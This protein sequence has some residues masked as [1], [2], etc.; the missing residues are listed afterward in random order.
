[1]RFSILLATAAT[2]L[3]TTAAISTVPHVLHEKRDAAPK[4]WVKR[5]RLIERDGRNKLPMR[6][7]MTQ[8]NLDIGDDL[9][10]EV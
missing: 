2:L 9:L 6:I 10:M 8:G 7:G 3:G 5:S 1:M 4:N